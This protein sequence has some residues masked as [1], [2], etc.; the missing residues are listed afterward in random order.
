MWQI[1]RLPCHSHSK[2]IT[3]NGELTSRNSMMVFMW[4]R[5]LVFKGPRNTNR[6]FAASS[7][8]VQNELHWG[9]S[10]TVE[11]SKQRNSYHSSSTFFCFESPTASFASQCSLFCTMWPD[12]AKGLFMSWAVIVHHMIISKSRSLRAAPEFG[13]TINITI[14]VSL[15]EPYCIV[16]FFRTCYRFF[17]WAISPW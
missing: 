9:A 11:L 7:H 8:M 17:P 15:S 4:I 13:W 1:N 2:N 12:P 10:D 3:G 6:P 14:F 16:F 5:W